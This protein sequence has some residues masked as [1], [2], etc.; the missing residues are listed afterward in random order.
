MASITSES[1]DSEIK[2]SKILWA[3]PGV[4][5]T[6][7]ALQAVLRIRQVLLDEIPIIGP[8]LS[9]FIHSNE[10]L[11]EAA[12][13][14]Y[15]NTAPVAVIFV[16]Y[17][18]C[19]LFQGIFTLIYR[20]RD[21]ARDVSFCSIFFIVLYITVYVP[22]LNNPSGYTIE[23]IIFFGVPFGIVVS[24]VLSFNIFP[25]KEIITDDIFDVLFRTRG[26]IRDTEEQVKTEIVKENTMRIIDVDEIL[27]KKRDI[28][29]SCRELLSEVGAK[30]KE[31][32]EEKKISELN[33]LLI[34]VKDLLSRA[35]KNQKGVEDIKKSIRSTLIR[36][37]DKVYTD[38]MKLE[39]EMNCVFELSN[40]PDYLSE[41]NIPNVGNTNIKKVPDVLK[42]MIKDEKMDIQE[43]DDVFNIAREHLNDVKRYIED[44]INPVDYKKVEIMI[45]NTEHDIVNLPNDLISRK[46]K[47]LYIDV[48][49]EYKELTLAKEKMH[50][51][52]KH[53]CELDFNKA[54][55]TLKEVKENIKVINKQIDFINV[56]IVAVENKWDSKK[57]TIPNPDILKDLSDE[58]RH[59][60]GAKYT[61]DKNA[62]NIYKNMLKIEY[63]P[64][65]A[66]REINVEKISDFHPNE[67]RAILYLIGE[68]IKDEKEHFVLLS[69]DDMPA[70]T[71]RPEV[72]K[73]F[74]NFVNE[75]LGEGVEKCDIETNF[76]C[77]HFGKK[78]DPIESINKIIEEHEKR[79]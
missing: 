72:L 49:T 59:V 67:V 3:L 34:T 21:I 51:V 20:N 71:K 37:V 22:L 19:W 46:L 30:E 77:I 35:E 4:V 66:K 26:I 78:L 12:V 57:I 75:V 31:A 74:K 40:L 64:I 54:M 42:S 52:K 8:F 6:I 9:S 17:A 10:F 14:F 62:L 65:L 69:K 25:W 28:E 15:Q 27:T 39:S 24:L 50:K 2:K 1:I 45:K 29:T 7:I 36:K 73:E 60:Y 56:M 18:V 76:I 32:K 48:P 13:I 43:F 44:Q 5:I 47:L 70:N 41:V 79:W 58:F 68:K 55:Q 53:I 16:L 38:V 11:S 63:E 61:T 23:K 33:N